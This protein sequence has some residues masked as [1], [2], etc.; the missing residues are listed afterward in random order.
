MVTVKFKNPGWGDN[1]SDMPIED[2]NTAYA[3]WK[4]GTPAATLA[5]QYNVNPWEL[6][7]LFDLR[8][9]SEPDG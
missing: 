2:Y 4:M 6:D 7:Y 8:R 1:I 9:S 3:L 5:E